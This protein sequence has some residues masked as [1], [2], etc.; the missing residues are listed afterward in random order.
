[1]QLERVAW[2][3]PSEKVTFEERLEG[4]KKLALWM[5]KENVPGRGNSC[6]KCPEIMSG[7]L[8][9]GLEATA[10]GAASGGDAGK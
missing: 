8:Q 3:S 5:S 6:H 7:K 1:M 10:A 2:E 4:G 9:G